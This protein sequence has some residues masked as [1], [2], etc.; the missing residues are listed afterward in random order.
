MSFARFGQFQNHLEFCHNPVMDYVEQFNFNLLTLWNLNRNTYE[1]ILLISSFLFN[2]RRPITI[3]YTK[4]SPRHSLDTFCK[5]E[6]VF[7]Y[8]G[9]VFLVR[10]NSN[11]RFHNGSYWVWGGL[12]CKVAGGVTWVQERLSDSRKTWLKTNT[13]K[14]IIQ[15][16][17]GHPVLWEVRTSIIHLFFSRGSYKQFWMFLESENFLKGCDGEQFTDWGIFQRRQLMMMS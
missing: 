9:V 17:Y 13:F 11:H 7:H 14:K 5:T 15:L 3:M 16:F 1:P 10:Y 6:R 8:K 4:V 12:Q 2:I